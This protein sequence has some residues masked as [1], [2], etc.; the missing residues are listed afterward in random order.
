M[1]VA[2]TPPINLARRL[3]AK[4]SLKPPIDVKSLVEAR[5]DLTIKNIPIEGVDGISLDLKTPG[6]KARVVL[7][8]SNPP[9]RQRFTLAHE[10][11][12]LLIPWHTGSII[13]HVDPTQKHVADNYWELESEANAF[14]GELL[15]PSQWVTQ[16]LAETAD[17]AKLHKRIAREC[18]VSLHAAAIRLSQLLPKNLVFAVERC[19]VVEFS[20][21]TVGT[22]ANPLPRESSFPD[23]AYDY[24]EEHFVATTDNRHIHWWKLPNSIALAANDERS[25]REILNSMVAALGIS[26]SEQVQIKSSV[27]GVIAY[28]NSAA[29]RSKDYSVD[30][31]VAAC[32]QRFNDRP[33]FKDFVHHPDFHAFIRQKALELVAPNR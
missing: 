19:G 12:H 23:E 13:D 10:L 27:N 17:M 30:T 4:L 33:E 31:V 9:T 29:K 5:A 21:R 14:A 8:G 28:A 20:G 2:A 7:N 11:G 22:L 3:I 1:A 24:F 26:P 16:L 18:D 25:W 6:K 32:I 15:V